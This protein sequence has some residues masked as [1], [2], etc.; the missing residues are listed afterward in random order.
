MVLRGAVDPIP[1]WLD[2]AMLMLR[3]GE[4]LGVPARAV[5]HQPVHLVTAALVDLAAANIAH[6]Q[7]V[8]RAKARAKRPASRARR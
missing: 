8:E 2:E 7:A 6:K 1:Y 4:K 5:A 3:L